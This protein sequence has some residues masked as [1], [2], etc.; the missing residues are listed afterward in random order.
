MFGKEVY[1]DNGFLFVNFDFTADHKLKDFKIYYRLWFNEYQYDDL[2][3]GIKRHEKLKNDI[4]N[5]F[6]NGSITG[7]SSTIKKAM[8]DY[9][10][11]QIQIPRPLIL[12]TVGDKDTIAQKN[13]GTDTPGT[14]K[15]E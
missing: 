2:E 4:T 1:Q 12:S 11:S 14:K 10:V 13:A 15:T 6:R 3:L 8:C 5:Y 7:I 9:L